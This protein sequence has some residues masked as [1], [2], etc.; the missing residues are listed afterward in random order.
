MPSTIKLREQRAQIWEQMKALTDLAEGEDRDFTAEERTSY[1]R[2]ESD[3]DS[4]GDRI[5]RSE[6]MDA[7]DA[8]LDRLPDR[9]EA[10]DRPEGTHED[11]GYA[12]AFSD[13]LRRG[14]NSIS[15]EHRELME[16]RASHD[17]GIQNAAGIGTGSAGGFT[18]PPAFRAVMIEAMKAYGVMLTEAETIT[19]ETGANLPWPTADDTA[20]VG[21]ILAENTP[22]TEQDFTFGSAS[23]DAYMYTS[24]LVR[25]SLQFLRDSSVAEQWLA[26]KLGERIGRIL[27]Q[28]FTTG[29]G[30]TLPDGIV[31][32]A[33]VGVT[34]SG[35][36]ASTGGYS[37]DNLVDLQESLDPAYGGHPD[38]KWMGHQGVRKALRKLKD[39]TGR[40]IWEPSVQAGASDT[41]LGRPFVVN[42][43]MAA[44]A[45][46]SK[47]LGYGSI[48]QAY[49]TR[50][51]AGSASLLRLTERYADY[52]QVG[53]L[54]FER[55]DGTLQD[56]GAFKV[57]QTTPTA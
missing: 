57:M 39:S 33:T 44:V 48:K 35:S 41:L 24:K 40:P 19:T 3:M 51:V 45:Q 50:Q 10:S 43:D 2:M 11:D 14:M 28:H 29:G 53:F 42:N 17:A 26:R 18:V 9:P 36:L 22:V 34:G 15:G 32:S 46:N 13:F 47:S 56:A 1:G 54:A 7:L 6:R 31:T 27:S 38:C 25:V 5:D 16:R 30:T 8:K 55:W 4:L 49:V 52:L 21:A 12:A 37:Y 23:L 20:N